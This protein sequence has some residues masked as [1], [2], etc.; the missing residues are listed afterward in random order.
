[1]K[2]LF[3]FA[4]CSFFLYA[5]LL[6]CPEMYGTFEISNQKIV[7][8]NGAEVGAG[9]LTI[10]QTSPTEDKLVGAKIKTENMEEKKSFFESLK[11]LFFK[12]NNKQPTVEL[13][14]HIPTAENPEI[15][16]MKKI[17]DGVK[18]P[19]A[20]K[21]KNGKVILGKPVK[22]ESGGKHLMLYNFPES[23]RKSEKTEIIL[24]FEKAGDVSVEF[25][26]NPTN[27]KEEKPCPHHNH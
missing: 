3:T 25:P 11:S 4:L 14:D 7:F 10:I 13:H 8:L 27:S 6:A 12:D 19:A 18:I 16:T 5:P 26:I 23:I 21:D 22:F 17:I 1:M 24:T 9:Y 2:R 20:S 15:V